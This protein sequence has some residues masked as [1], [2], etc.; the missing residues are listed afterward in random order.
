MASASILI[1]GYRAYDELEHCLA[2]VTLHEPDAE[3][4][5]IDHAADAQRSEALARTFPS[6]RYVSR[7]ENPGFGAGIN[8]AARLASR[9]LFLLLNPDM[10]LHAPVVARLAGAF[11]ADAAVGV[12]GGQIREPDGSVQASARRFPDV[13][14]AF[15]GRTSWLT[16][17]APGNPLSRRNLAAT[18]PAGGRAVVDWVTGAFMMI[19]RDL[20]ERIG[21]FDERFFLYWEDAD[22]C[23][24]AA[25]AGFVTVYEPSAEAVHLTGR[26]SRHAPWRSLAAFHRSVFRYYWKHGSFIARLFSPLVALG[27]AVRFVLVGARR[28]FAS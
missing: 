28:T 13:T 11:A 1:V 16:R 7:S 6:V 19:R 24:R 26:A 27:L 3:I 18:E 5:V 25:A 12:A 8:A 9:P 10:Q 2:S 23:R 17:I 21:G 14:T 4:I 20:F 22:F 15:G